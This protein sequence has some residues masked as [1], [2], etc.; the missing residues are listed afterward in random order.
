[1]SGSLNMMRSSDQQTCGH[2]ASKYTFRH[3]HENRGRVD[4]VWRS[5]LDKEFDSE[6]G[7]QKIVGSHHRRCECGGVIRID[8]REWAVCENPKCS[9]IH[10]DVLADLEFEKTR[11]A[12]SMSRFIKTIKATV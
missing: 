5:P 3:A 6:W 2:R 9:R 7:Y 10:N 12:I 8:E 4:K 1:M 11:Q